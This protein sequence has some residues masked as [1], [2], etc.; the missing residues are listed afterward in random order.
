M[1]FSQEHLKAPYDEGTCQTDYIYDAGILP[2]PAG[3]GNQIMVRTHAANSRRVVRFRVQRTGA[4][5][6]L[7][8]PTPLNDNEVLISSRVTPMWPG[9]IAAGYVYMVEG[10]YTFAQ[11]RAW[12]PGRDT[13]PVGTGPYDVVDPSQSNLTPEMFDR[14]REAQPIVLQEAI[15]AR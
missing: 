12:V 14:R 9:Q 11:K 8:S 6:I 15:A 2:L 5:P 4:W 1:P 3:Q 7:P 10:V 13:L